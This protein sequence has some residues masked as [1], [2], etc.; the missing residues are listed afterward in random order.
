MKQIRYERF[1]TPSRVAACV[2]VPPPGEPSA[3]EVTVDIAA[4]CINPSD[5]SML[6]GQYG[7]L[8]AR[9]P[10][11]L[12]LEASG[13]VAAVGASVTSF[14]PGDRVIV[15]ANDNWVQRRNVPANA[16][17][18]APVDMDLNQLAMIKVNSLCA[19]LMLSRVTELEA[20]DLVIQSAPLS[21]VGRMVIGCAKVMG[22]KTVNIVRRTDAIND[23]KALGG[24]LVLMDDDDLAKRVLEASGDEPCRLALDPVG[25]EL[26]L[27]LA[28]CLDKGGIILNYGMLSGEPCQL[29]P[30]QAIFNDIRLQGFWLSKLLY[31]MTQKERDTALNETLTIVREHQLQNQIAKTFPLHQIASALDFAENPD[32]RGKVLLYPN[33]EPNA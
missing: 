20:G 25:G 14:K 33:G 32:R 8:P 2:D 26:T 10:A 31:R 4:T 9:F 23:V 28:D 29:R 30:D 6:R 22:L 16:L 24:D 1:G 19:H 5:I 15:I 3:W 12:G 7:T 21:A 11:T 18:K 17:F 13:V 27:R